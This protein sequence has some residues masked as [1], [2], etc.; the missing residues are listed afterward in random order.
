MAIAR[1]ENATINE[2][3]LGDTVDD[4]G[5][6]TNTSTPLFTSRALVM[7]VRNSLRISEKYRVYQDLVNLTFNYTPNIKKIVDDQDKYSITW[8]NKDWRVSDVIE[9]DDRMRITLLCYFANPSVP[10]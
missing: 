1:Y 9:S 6:Y 7:D 4:F 8:R 3:S 10:V 5:Q 2:I